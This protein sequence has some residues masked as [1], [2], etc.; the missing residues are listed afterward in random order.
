MGTLIAGWHNSRDRT[1]AIAILR[2]RQP[3]VYDLPRLDRAEAVLAEGFAPR[4]QD[5]GREMWE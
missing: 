3:T 1:G 2:D 5:L 4:L